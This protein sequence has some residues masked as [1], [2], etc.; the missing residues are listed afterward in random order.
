M[1]ETLVV[2]EP[3]SQEPGQRPPSAAELDAARELV[4]LAR[5]RGVALT[6]PD[7]LLKAVTKTV[8]ETALD[9]EM[10]EHLGYDRH[11]PA[12]RNRGNSRN[13]TRAKTV[14]SDAAGPVQID[15]PR[16]RDGTFEPQLVKKRQR[17]LSDVDEVVL[18][19]YAKGLT[20]GEISA[21]F[22]DVFPTSWADPQ[23][24][25]SRRT[26]SPGSPTG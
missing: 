4:R 1:T 18:S 15:V 10:S 17:R 9:E 14:L 7:G 19:V 20:T 22:A 24:R 16:D 6:G 26:P 3:P 13:G 8:I 2:V 5:Q 23:A 11:D 12:G 21:H 25:P